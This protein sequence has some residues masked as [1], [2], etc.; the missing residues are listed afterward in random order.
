MGLIPFTRV[1]YFS[2]RQPMPWCRFTENIPSPN[3]VLYAFRPLASLAFFSSSCMRGVQIEHGPKPLGPWA[4]SQSLQEVGRAHLSYFTAGIFDISQHNAWARRETDAVAQEM[5]ATDDWLADFVS[6][7]PASP[8]ARE[9]SC[10][11][12]DGP[13]SGLSKRSVE[14]TAKNMI[15]NF[16]H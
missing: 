8:K 15:F 13:V 12:S 7:M 9:G 16:S 5:P 10:A 14:E 6:S 2:K 11:E 1:I 4:A 3:L